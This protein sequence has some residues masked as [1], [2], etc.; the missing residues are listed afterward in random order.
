M[1]RKSG[2]RLKAKTGKQSAREEEQR[3]LSGHR[4]ML[5]EQ[6]FTRGIESIGCY[7]HREEEIP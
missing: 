2:K 4:L 7:P 1:I 3:L 5:Y 6:Y